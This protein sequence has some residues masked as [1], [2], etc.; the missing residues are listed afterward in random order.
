MT[1]VLVTPVVGT[2]VNVLPSEVVPL[3]VTDVGASGV[4]V[5]NTSLRDTELEVVEDD[6]TSGS[7]V[8]FV[9]GVVGE[10]SVAVEA[11][12]EGIA[13]DAVDT[14]VAVAESVLVVDTESVGDT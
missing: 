8:D 4:V 1:E 14:G 9:G 2:C 11:E 10:A 5:F 3:V 7:L 13:V 6:V 12:L